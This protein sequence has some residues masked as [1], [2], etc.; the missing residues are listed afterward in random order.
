MIDS[1]DR[2]RILECK[3]ELQRFLGEDELKDA[4]ILIMANKQ[5]L[6]NAMSAEE[7][8][9]KL[10]LHKVRGRKICKYKKHCMGLY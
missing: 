5:D 7:V 1:N 6:P 10:E 4:A 2:D 8:A 9:E 3:D